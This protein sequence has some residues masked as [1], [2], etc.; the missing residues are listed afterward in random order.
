M[1][2]FDLVNDISYAKKY[3]LE[4]EKH[5]LPF[6]VNT[7]FS[8]FGDSIFF[9]NEMN[10]NYHLDKKLQHD[11]YFHALRKNK[12]KSKWHK[13]GNEDSLDCIQRYYGYGP[14]KAKEAAKILSKKQVEYIVKKMTPEA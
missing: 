6:I 8:Y 13:K 11:Y 7:H 9:A 5:Y 4:E 1:N 10:M 14:Q 3:I 12:R 2:P